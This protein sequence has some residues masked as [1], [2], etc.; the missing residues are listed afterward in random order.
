MRNRI[1]RLGT[2][3]WDALALAWDKYLRIDG[4]ER[5]GSFA[6]NAFFSLFPLVVLF[7]TIISLFIDRKDAAHFVIN[8]VQSHMPLSADMR[9]Y[10][11][12]TIGGVVA[13]RREAGLA[14]FLMLLWAAPQ[15]LG[16]LIQASNRAWGEKG[17]SWWRL[18]IK[19]LLLLLAM[20]ATVIIGMGVPALVNLANKI[21]PG[22]GFISWAYTLTAF[23][24]PWLVFFLNMS[25]FY[26]LAPRRKT[27]FSEVWIS[28][29]FATALLLAAQKLFVVYMAHFA[30]LNAIYGAFGGVMALLLWIYLSGTIFIY[31]ACLCA[32]QRELRE[33]ACAGAAAGR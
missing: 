14:A 25:L 13:A 16:T 15:F 28:A 6:F 32:A 5:A 2:G 4:T 27:Q 8:Y 7:V 9:K 17:D 22:H 12:S 3:A 18:P 21:F 11:F 31:C 10:I 30:T 26:R 29:L 20:G 33:R 24:L 19:S 23:F 1:K